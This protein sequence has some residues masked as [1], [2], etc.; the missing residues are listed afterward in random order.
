MKSEAE[1]VVQALL[2]DADVS[3]IIG[4]NLFPESP[5]SEAAFPCLTYSESQSPAGAAD[6]A[7]TLTQVVFVFESF[8]RGSAWNL[9]TA[10]DAVM[11]G[12]GYVRGYAQSAGMTGAVNQVSSKYITLKE[13]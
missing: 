8:V 2:D 6:N 11:L 10:V 5:P 9:A 12:L 7:E 4:T 3:A 13:V 1:T